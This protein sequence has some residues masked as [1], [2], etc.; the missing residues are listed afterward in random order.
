MATMQ[1]LADAQRTYVRVA[2]G[3]PDGVGVSRAESYRALHAV[4]HPPSFP[5]LH[6]GGG[7]A[8]AGGSAARAGSSL[9]VDMDSAEGSTATKRPAAAADG[10]EA[11]AAKKA[12]PAQEDVE[13]EMEA[14]EEEEEDSD[15]W[16]ATMYYWRGE[17]SFD[18][19]KK[20][21]TWKGAWVGSTRGLPSDQ[22]FAAS[23]NA[24]T[25]TSAKI[26]GGV[27]LSATA[28]ELEPA[29]GLKSKFTGSYQ[30]DQGDGLETFSDK[31][32]M[33]KISA[34]PDGSVL[35]AARGTTEFG[36]FVSAG[37]LE[38]GG[39]TGVQLTL[40]RRYVD[41]ADPRK[42]W[43]TADRVTTELLSDRQG[44][45]A[46]GGPWRAAAMKLKLS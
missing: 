29:A 27:S 41:D 25:L 16:K 9:E 19:G 12:K 5:H 17:L 36:A 37:R 18:G 39:S 22:E 14:E 13:M 6:F 24:F 10:E 46:D 1:A 28:A 35:V 32:H 26:K 11:P 42:K 38:S 33:F 8:G 3:D 7:A 15:D 45:F 43:T 34:A 20:M 31:T 2:T 30:L 21:L 23:P 40:A 4:Y 44:A